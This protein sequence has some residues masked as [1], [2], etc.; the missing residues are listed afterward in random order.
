MLTLRFTDDNGTLFSAPPNPI[1]RQP[2]TIF[3]RPH[4]H[5]TSSRPDWRAT[6]PEGED[7]T[8]TFRGLLI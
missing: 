3:Y 1:T 4:E 8:G 5:W 2:A 7:I 6:L